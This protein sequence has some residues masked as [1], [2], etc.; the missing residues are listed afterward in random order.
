MGYL[1]NVMSSSQREKTHEY[2]ITTLAV[3]RSPNTKKKLPIYKT[4]L[5]NDMD[6]KKNDR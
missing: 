1:A 3:S 4:K 2:I 6:K 5:R